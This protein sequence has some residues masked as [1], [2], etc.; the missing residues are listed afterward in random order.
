VCAELDRRG[1][2]PKQNAKWDS[3]ALQVILKWY[4]LRRHTMKSAGTANEMG[5]RV[6]AW[7][8]HQRIMKLNT[9]GRALY[10]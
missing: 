9:V 3:S 4:N 1:F 6:G 10:D 8:M 7:R 5:M 2:K